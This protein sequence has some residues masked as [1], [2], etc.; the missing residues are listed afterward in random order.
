[1][2]QCLLVLSLM[3]MHDNKLLTGRSDCVGKMLSG[4]FDTNNLS[5]VFIVSLRSS[6]CDSNL[7]VTAVAINKI[8]YIYIYSIPIKYRYRVL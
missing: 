4:N 7:S 2:V 1:M 3:V 5:N 6:K 8:A